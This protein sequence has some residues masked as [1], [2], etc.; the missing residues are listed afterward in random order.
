[1]SNYGI[2]FDPVLDLSVKMAAQKYFEDHIG[3][4]EAFRR[5]FGKSWL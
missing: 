3:D 1:M 5:E 4:R 2:H